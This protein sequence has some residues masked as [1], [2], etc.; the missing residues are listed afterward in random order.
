MISSLAD[1]VSSVAKT[2]IRFMFILFKAPPPFANSSTKLFSVER[3]SFH[4]VFH[5]SL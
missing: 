3:I 5:V 2:Y 1:A 4:L